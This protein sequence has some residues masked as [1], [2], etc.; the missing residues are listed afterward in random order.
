MCKNV[1][2]HTSRLLFYFSNLFF[3][4]QSTSGYMK[5]MF[6]LKVEQKWIWH[7]EKM[8]EGICTACETCII[9]VIKNLAWN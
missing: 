3:Y 2:S 5:A 9:T 6:Y 8:Q 1:R 4:A 7:S